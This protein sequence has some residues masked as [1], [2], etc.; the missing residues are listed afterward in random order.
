MFKYFNFDVTWILI[1]WHARTVRFVEICVET[2]TL[3]ITLCLVDIFDLCTVLS[4]IT[5]TTFSNAVL[6]Y[7]KQFRVR[8]Q[9]A[10]IKLIME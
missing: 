1:G 6:D 9:D 4:S 8:V 10:N 7:R 5:Y 2:N 3:I